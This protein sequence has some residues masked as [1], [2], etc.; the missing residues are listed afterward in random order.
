[1]NSIREDTEWYIAE[2]VMEITVRGAT[3]NAIHLNLILISAISPEE[4][5]RK[6]TRFGYQAETSYENPSGQTVEIRFRGIARLDEAV[7]GTLED[8]SELIFEERFGVS[9]TEIEKMIPPKHNLAVFVS[10]RPG[11]KRDPD[12]RSAAVMQ[13]AVEMLKE[14]QG[15]KE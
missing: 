9:P 5:Y 6:A 1:M 14:P 10:P 3:R 4:A 7:D 11:G 12:Y 13:R 8:G 2:V 15:D